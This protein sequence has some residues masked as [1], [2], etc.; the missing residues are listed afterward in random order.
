LAQ[1]HRRYSVPKL[2]VPLA[3]AVGFADVTPVTEDHIFAVTGHQTILEAKAKEL[4]NCL[5]GH[6]GA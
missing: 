2:K 6:G 1:Q 5:I 3:D 4:P